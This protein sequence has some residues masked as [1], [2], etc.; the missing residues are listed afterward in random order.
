MRAGR[1]ARIAPAADE[2]APVTLPAD[3]A[4][5]AAFADGADARWLQ[6][7]GWSESVEPDEGGP[8]SGGLRT[9]AW[10]PAVSG[11]P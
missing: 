9:F 11:L 8:T 4:Q 6:R 3:V 7:L 10:P 1:I 5:R 2:T